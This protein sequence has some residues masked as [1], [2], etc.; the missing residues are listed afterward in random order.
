MKKYF[1]AVTMLLS[2]YTLF[3]QDTDKLLSAY[4]SVKDALVATDSKASAKATGD[5]V[6][7][8]KTG[9]DF[10]QK[11]DLL[12]AAEAMNKSTDIEKQRRAFEKVST[13]MWDVVKQSGTLSRDVYYQ[14]CPMKKAYWLSNEADIKNPYYGAKML[15]CGSVKDKKLK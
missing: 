2:G 5:F 10:A 15:T 12:K 13:I 4:L 9:Q 1:L 7:A 8:I 14:Y 3:A 11:N 6:D